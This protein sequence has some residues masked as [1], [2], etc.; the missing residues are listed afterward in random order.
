[1]SITINYKTVFVSGHLKGIFVDRQITIPSSEK[2]Y[3]EK[4]F[5]KDIQEQTTYRDMS[6]NPYIITKVA[7]D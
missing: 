6:G 7:F 5:L 2:T 3:H 1:M 4:W